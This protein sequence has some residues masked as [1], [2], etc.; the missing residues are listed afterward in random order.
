MKNTNWLSVLV[1]GGIML[2]NILFWLFITLKGYFI[3]ALIS[4]FVIGALF[5]I[6]MF[7]ELK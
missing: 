4:Y 5:I 1:W 6:L 7:K 3:Q 2:F